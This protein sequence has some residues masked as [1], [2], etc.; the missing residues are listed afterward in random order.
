MMNPAFVEG[1][2]SAKKRL[3][4]MQIRLVEEPDQVRQAL[5]EIY[6]AVALQTPYND[7]STH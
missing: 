3:N 5:L 7:F 6:C 2:K 4:Q 1:F